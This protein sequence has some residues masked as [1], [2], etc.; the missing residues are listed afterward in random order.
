MR[1]SPM[2]R[3]L[4]PRALA[5]C[6]SHRYLCRRTGMAHISRSSHHYCLLVKYVST[7]AMLRLEVALGADALPSVRCLTV[8]DTAMTAKTRWPGT[9]T[10][11]IPWMPT[12]LGPFGNS[13]S[14]S[15]FFP[16]AARHCVKRGHGE[17]ACA[18]RKVT[19]DYRGV[20]SG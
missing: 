4:M 12:S 9:S 2:A 15:T 13:A 8:T 20:H 14:S 19:S 17:V 3:P 18:S 6:S 5:T 7:V 10:S 1:W 16:Q 11:Y